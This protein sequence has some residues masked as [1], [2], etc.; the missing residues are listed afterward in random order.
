LV[1]GFTNQEVG[2]ERGRMGDATVAM[3]FVANTVCNKWIY[4]SQILE[5]IYGRPNNRNS[6]IGNFET[7]YNNC[8]CAVIVDV[9]L[10]TGTCI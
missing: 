10:L 5:Q 6:Q 8:R 4:D 2:L 1:K 9:G 7:K 3:L